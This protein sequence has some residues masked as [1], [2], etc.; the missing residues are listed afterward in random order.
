MLIRG[1]GSGVLADIQ[2]IMTAVLW[3]LCWL[4]HV[5]LPSPP[6]RAHC[7]HSMVFLGVDGVV[8][9]AACDALSWWWSLA[10]NT[11]DQSFGGSYIGRYSFYD[12][13]CSRAESHM[14]V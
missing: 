7:V 6:F 10:R 2:S 1:D 4:I 8:G 12:A 14:G 9:H 11:A 5:F 3:R 13:G